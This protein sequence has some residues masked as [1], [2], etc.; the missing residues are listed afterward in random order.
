M[1]KGIKINFDVND[2]I[3]E[4]YTS[5]NSQGDFVLYS[6][7]I[8]E[9]SIII[10]GTP[11][12]NANNI[13]YVK[14][15]T[16]KNDRI[17][18][19]TIERPSNIVAP[20][21]PTLTSTPTKTPTKTPTT[22]L[23]PTPTSTVT[24]TTGL[25]P[26]PTSTTG[27][28]PT[29]TSTVGSTTPT[30]TRTPTTTPTYVEAFNVS[31][32]VY[33]SYEEF[34]NNNSTLKY[35]SNLTDLYNS[36]MTETNRVSVIMENIKTDNV[37]GIV[38]GAKIYN[39]SNVLFNITGYMCYINNNVFKYIKIVNSIITEIGNLVAP[40]NSVTGTTIL[41][42]YYTKGNDN[43]TGWGY[44][45]GYGNW[46]H[47]LNINNDGLTLIYQYNG[48]NND[49]SIASSGTF[50]YNYSGI[51]Y[52]CKPYFT[53]NRRTKNYGLPNSYVIPNMYRGT[54]IELII[55]IEVTQQTPATITEAIALIME[56]IRREF[57]ISY[58]IL[59]GK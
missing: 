31:S 41:F 30:I 25:T 57:N 44:L 26:T 2:D 6:N 42:P 4:V 58:N 10:S 56:N 45:E 14:L 51:N 28:T 35:Y 29:P 12:S 23:T 21:T 20:S 47:R 22:G 43:S 7:N 38:V 49:A 27:L 34:N 53:I 18:T 9:D 50:I 24:S 52:I 33:T 1:G 3:Y 37:N 13:L 59:I 36:I 39:S 16:N 48:G 8:I 55:S 54:L 11:L 15:I 17:I 5:N 40:S 46:S 19:I 32:F